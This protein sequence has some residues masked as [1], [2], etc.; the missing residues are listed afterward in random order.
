MITLVCEILNCDAISPFVSELTKRL[1]PYIGT[2]ES[3]EWEA[4]DSPDKPVTKR[5][6]KE[7]IEKLKREISGNL[8]E[9]NDRIKAL[10]SDSANLVYQPPFCSTQK[11][12]YQ[13][14]GPLKLRGHFSHR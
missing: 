2:R 5:E 9:L 11:L 12:A 4:L 8:I 14:L 13:P 1:L 6:L 3:W 7:E 10:K